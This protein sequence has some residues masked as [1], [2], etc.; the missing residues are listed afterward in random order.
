M[1][2]P[3]PKRGRPPKQPDEPVSLAPLEFEDALR[4]LMATG[5]PERDGET[6]EGEAER[7]EGH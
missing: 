1:S 3:K 2:E 5:K 6:D 4:D 7:R